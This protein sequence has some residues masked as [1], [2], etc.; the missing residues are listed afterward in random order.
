[1]IVHRGCSWSMGLTGQRRAQ[2]HTC[3]D[4]Y[5]QLQN[6]GCRY[7]HGYDKGETDTNEEGR[8]FEKGRKRGM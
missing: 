4:V 8:G 7:G 1:M 6:D 3:S 2:I 5:Q